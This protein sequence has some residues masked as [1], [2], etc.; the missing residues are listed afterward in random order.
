MQT[1]ENSFTVIHIV[2][3]GVVEDLPRCQ[4][5][6]INHEIAYCFILWLALFANHVNYKINDKVNT[7]TS[8]THS[9]ETSED[10]HII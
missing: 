7:Q 9:L 6:A 5:G 10:R 1:L 2:P 8:M 4:D 3:I